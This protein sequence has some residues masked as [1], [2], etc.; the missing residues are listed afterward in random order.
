VPRGWAEDPQLGRWVDT[1]RA[2]KKKLGRGKPSKGMTAAR[3]AMLDKLGFDWAPPRGGSRGVARGIHG[4]STCDRGTPDC[5]GRQG[6]R[7]TE[8]RP[9]TIYI[10][11]VKHL[12]TCKIKTTAVHDIAFDSARVAKILN[13]QYLGKPIALLVRIK[14]NSHDGA[15]EL[16]MPLEKLYA[17]EVGTKIVRPQNAEG[18]SQTMMASDATYK[19]GARRLIAG[20]IRNMNDS[21]PALLHAA[22]D[23]RVVT[24]P[25]ILNSVA[26]AS[27]DCAMSSISRPIVAMVSTICSNTIVYVQSPASCTRT[28][29]A[30]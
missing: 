29:S 3:A 25:I 9:C 4:G 26:L 2:L 28:R 14:L 16:Q 21:W 19:Q 20:R 6:S 17:I 8:E 13:E 30:T 15:F 18:I 11:A 27:H 22:I 12:P 10:K 5:P 1:Q 7:K 24:A 23:A